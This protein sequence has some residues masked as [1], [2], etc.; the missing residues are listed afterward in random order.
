MESGRPYSRLLLRLERFNTLSAD[1]RQRLAN[2]P[3]KLVSYP[4]REVVSRGC[5]TSR[6]TLV[7]DGFL[8]S[9]KAALGSR[10]QITS[11]FVPGDVADLATLYLPAVDHSI[12]TLGPAVLALVP[13]SVLK[14]AIDKS[15]SL[16]HSFWRETLIQ[17]AIFQEW[18]VNLGRRDAFARLA[19]ILCELTVRLQASGLARDLSFAMPWTQLHV[20]DACGI[21]NVHANRVIQEFRHLGILEWDSRRLTIHDWNAMTRL[22]DFNRPNLNKDS[23]LAGRTIPEVDPARCLLPRTN[24]LASSKQI[25]TDRPE[26]RIGTYASLRK[27][28]EEP[29]ATTHL[30]CTEQTRAQKQY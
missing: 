25:C 21:S 7:L 30:S 14:E 24:F 1:D 28:N 8:Y 18:V 10:R 27:R 4:A 26:A 15:T 23:S 20:A 29:E 22:G 13:H 9:H 11:F 6:C 12:S 16:S 17:A 5:S 2:L 19:H 3:L